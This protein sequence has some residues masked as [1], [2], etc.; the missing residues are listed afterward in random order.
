MRLVVEDLVCERSGRPVFSGVSFAVDGGQALALVGRNG[1]GKSSLLQILAGLLDPA[2]GR[3]LVDEGHDDRTL[4]EQ[5]HYVGH[6][7]ALKPSLTPHET[8][9]FWRAMLGEPALSPDEALDRLGLGHA[10][11]LPCA[12]LSAGQR[13]RL[14]LARLLVSDRPVWLLDEP[15]SALDAASQGVFADLVRDH[16]ARGGIVLA[17]THAPLGLA[18]VATLRIGPPPSGG[19]A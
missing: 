12:Y 15:T 19:A 8:L 4:G 11:D 17:A 6:R 18:D 14:A 16:L 1:A 10:A 3:I 9:A 5:S 13:R 2:S 7:D